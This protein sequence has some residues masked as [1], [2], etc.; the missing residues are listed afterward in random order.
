MR[1]L[2]LLDNVENVVFPSANI[3][4]GCRYL[5]GLVDRAADGA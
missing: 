1:Y 3:G 4:V 2:L 5:K